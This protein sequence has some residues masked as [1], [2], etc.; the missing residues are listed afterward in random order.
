M[1]TRRQFL[2]TMGAG[3]AGVALSG[4]PS[5]VQA[6][7]ALMTSH[8][9]ADMKRNKVRVAFIGIGN[10]GEQDFDDFLR[11]G[12]VEVAALCDVDLDGKQCQKVLSRFPK[13]KRFR[14]FRE[15]FEKA[16]NDFDA[17]VAAVPDHI[18]FP[19]AMMALTHGKHIYLEKPMVRTF[20]EAELLMQ[21]ARRHPELATQVGNQ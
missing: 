14:D 11:T 18:H 21:M 7:P 8:E 17:V 5:F 4:L 10:R 15:L 12:M 20:L 16:A 19:I 6:A 9:T 3:M 13:V 1:T 2:K